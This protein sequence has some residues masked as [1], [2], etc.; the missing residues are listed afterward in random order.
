M[1]VGPLVIEHLTEQGNIPKNEFSFFMQT[2]EEGIS[3]IDIGPAQ[4]DSMKNGSSDDSVAIPINKDFFWSQYLQGIAFGDTRDDNAYTFEE[5]WPYT[6]T[7]TGSS[8]LFVPESYYEVII[9]KLIEAAGNPEYVIQQGITLTECSN[10]FRPLYLMMDKHWIVID[11]SEYLFDVSENGDNSV[12]HIMILG[13][14]YGFFLVGLPFF[15]GYYT[16][17]DMDEPSITYIPHVDSSKDYLKSGSV[18]EQFLEPIVHN[19]FVEY[20]PLVFLAGMAALYYF[21]VDPW[22]LRRYKNDDW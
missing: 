7:D 11:P 5:G 2:V 6:I 4:I 22:S 14:S 20:L 16:T 3:H 21:V 13:N 17:H 19:Y 10:K 15:Q 8:H 18:P 1:D 12:C 9:V